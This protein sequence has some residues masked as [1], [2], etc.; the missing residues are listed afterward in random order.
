MQYRP[1]F[2]NVYC[3]FSFLFN[4]HAGGREGMAK[5]NAENV[6][7]KFIGNLKKIQEKL[8]I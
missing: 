4:F 6:V 1:D 2:S 5:A 3:F 7:K 8:P